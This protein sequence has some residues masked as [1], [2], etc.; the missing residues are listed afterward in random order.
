MELKKS[1]HHGTFMENILWITFYNHISHSIMYY[2]E[3]HKIICYLSDYFC[4]NGSTC[5][6]MGSSTGELLRILSTYHNGK[7]IKWDWDR[8]SA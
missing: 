1:M 2:D 8:C 4:R 6:D 7:D 5:Y 3:G